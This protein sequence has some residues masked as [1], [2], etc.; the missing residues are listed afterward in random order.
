MKKLRLIAITL[1]VL[2]LSA[3][4]V[5]ADSTGRQAVIYYNEACDECATYING[6]LQEILQANQVQMVR[7][8]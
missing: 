5:N 3:L 8:D 6:E 2:L 1:F 7:K 4:P